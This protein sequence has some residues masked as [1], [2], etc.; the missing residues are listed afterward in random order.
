[1][2]RRGYTYEEPGAASLAL[3]AAFETGELTLDGLRSAEIH[4]ATADAECTEVTGAL[5]A[6]DEAYA[7]AAAELTEE[8]RGLLRLAKE[9]KMDAMSRVDA[10][11]ERFE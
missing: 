5:R 9:H 2:R 7:H 11:L 6:L 10:A 3:R 4:I 8:H 1:M